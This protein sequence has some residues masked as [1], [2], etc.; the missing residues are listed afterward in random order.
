MKA[1][2]L[3]AGFG[4][5]LRPLTEKLPK[6][7]IPVANIP[8]LERNVEYLKS[9]EVEDIVINAYYLSESISNFILKKPIPKVKLTVRTE[10]EI[11]GT[12]GGIANCADFFSEGTFV[13]INGDIL[14]N[15]DINAAIKKHKDAG[16]LVTMVLHDHESFNQIVIDKDNKVRK[17]HKDKGPGR[18]AFTGIHILEPEIFDHMPK[19]GF[20]D[21]ILDCYNPLIKSGKMTAHTVSGH[22]W[23]DIG[24]IKSYIEANK[25]FL[26]FKNKKTLSGSGTHIDPSVTLREWAIIGDNVHIGKNT[27]IER[28]IIWDNTHIG[29]DILIK[30]SIVTSQCTVMN[31][32]TGKIII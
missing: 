11:L 1:M 9:F 6:A 4:T 23:H 30:D 22:Y 10:K 21:I 14:T 5:R 12:G 28:S 24:T 32:L 16:N 13:V 3:A 25:H 18:L 17:I 26:K 2:I 15:I 31:S 19:K 27:I 29:N 8:L 7:L 20:S